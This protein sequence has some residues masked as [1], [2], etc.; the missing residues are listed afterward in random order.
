M[1]V[2]EVFRFSFKPRIFSIFSS[3]KTQ[4]Q[5]L[6][7][8]EESLILSDVSQDIVARVIAVI[9][10]KTRG[11][12]QKAE[13]LDWIRAEL[14]AIFSQSR[15]PVAHPEGKNVLVLVGVNGSG[16]TTTAAKLAFSVPGFRQADI[17]LCGRHI[18]GGRVDPDDPLGKKTGHPGDR[19]RPGGRFG[20]RGVQGDAGF[21]EPGF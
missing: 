19:R 17:A 7:E 13:Y 21:Y 3:G 9:R 12:P 1:G 2:K 15:A 10:K 14:T 8:L 20:S 16:K 5:I 6:E 4:A 18:P 11:N